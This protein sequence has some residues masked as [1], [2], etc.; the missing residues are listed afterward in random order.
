MTLIQGPPG[1]GKTFVGTLI[2]KLMLQ[3]PTKR[4]KILCVTYTNHALDD[5]LEGLVKAGV[6]GIVRIGKRSSNPISAPYSLS[7]LAKNV[8]STSDAAF[9]RRYAVLKGSVQQ[10]SFDFLREQSEIMTQ[11][12]PLHKQW[13]EIEIYLDAIA[14]P[15]LEELRVKVD[16]EGGFT[17]VGSG[18]KALR[19]DK[20]WSK[21]VKGKPHPYSSGSIS[22]SSCWALHP[23]ER[24]T[25]AQEW[26]SDIL[27]DTIGRLQ[28]ALESCVDTIDDF[29][30]LRNTTNY[31]LIN[32]AQVI[33]CTTS[34]AAKNFDLLAQAKCDVVLVE[35]AGEILEPHILSSIYAKCESLIMIGDHLQLRPK[36]ASDSH[37][38]LF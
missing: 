13:P 33:M 29:K 3:H 25:L 34:G 37:D 9:N 8:K 19:P 16:L 11:S 4:L 38:V 32:N 18:G 20:L 27:H 7:E 30:D 15:Y 22:T 10:N 2:T 5:F 12:K 28:V 6:G 24:L 1:T 21:W 31:D 14:S 23:Q 26:S 36:V 17:A 35:E